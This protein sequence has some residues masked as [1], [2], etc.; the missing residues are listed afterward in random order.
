MQIDE[1]EGMANDGEAVNGLLAGR[2]RAGEFFTECN[3][4]DELELISTK[5]L[6]LKIQILAEK[7]IRLYWTI[8]SLKSYIECNRVPRGL[9]VFKE[10]SQFKEDPGFQKAWEQI[11]LQCSQNLLQLVTAQ[12]EKDYASIC[13]QLD[14][15]KQELSSRIS[16]DNFKSFEKKLEK[17]LIIVQ[18]DTK[19]KKKEKFLRDKRDFESGQIFTWNKGTGS[20]NRS[21]ARNR[22]RKFGK[23]QKISRDGWITD[24]D[25][26]ATEEVGEDVASTPN[27]TSPVPSSS[28]SQIPLGGK[29][30]GEAGE[31]NSGD[32]L[33][34]LNDFIWQPT[35]S[36]ASIDI[37]NL[38]TRI[39]QQKGLEAIQRILA[40]TEKDQDFVSFILEG[41]D[42]V[43][44]NNTF[45]FMDKWYS[46]R[47]GT[48]M[49]TPVACVFANLFLAAFEEKHVTGPLNPYLKH[50]RLYLRFADDVFIV[51]DGGEQTFND[52]VVFLNENNNENMKFT[53]Y[54]VLFPS[55]LHSQQIENICLQLQNAE[56]ES[57]LKISL[58]L[59]N[60]D[61]I[62]LEKIFQQDT[63]F[64]C[65]SLQ[66]PIA[67][68]DVSVGILTIS[69][70]SSGELIN[71]SSKVLVKKQLYKTLVQTDKPVYKPGQTVNFR[72]L[73]INEDFKPE[74]ISIP[75]IEVQD[76]E[77]NRIG[78]WLN[79]NLHQ[80][81]AEFSLVL[82]SEPTLGEYSIKL[83]GKSYTFTVEEYVL[84]KFEV[85]IQFPKY[86][87]FNSKEFPVQVCGKGHKSREN[88]N[89]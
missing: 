88:Q 60:K 32:F 84:P 56:G 64:T 55:E 45:K 87:M 53:H 17:K 37:V 9:R 21:F 30:S 5:S 63:T 25:S 47:V 58:N 75:V 57:N 76:P 68:E 19:E 14:K 77:K 10:I 50:I 15:S 27:V 51:W 2:E 65:F 52:F 31:K 39:P 26:S 66:V 81:I 78:Q 79:V 85:D 48:A 43:L 3:H 20:S 44:S 59:S 18:M 89:F 16:K 62:L 40:N 38:Y 4:K 24:S 54:A 86:V 12:N 72:I 46:Q 36:L 7:E 41:L 13:E 70:E 28:T 80:G 73:S 6:E 82:S 42:F 74:N 23:K 61:T 1:M 11:H 34:A 8:K 29:R 69:I 33:L 35:F 67:E 71:K 49:G 83:K 22:S